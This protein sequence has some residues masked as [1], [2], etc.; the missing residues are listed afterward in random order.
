MPDESSPAMSNPAEHTVVETLQSL[1]VAFV[2]AMTFRGFVTEGF[3]IPTGSMAP[4]LYGQHKRLRGNQTGFEH[5]MG[6]DSKLGHEPPL[7]TVPDPIL[8]PNFPNT[9]SSRALARTRMGDRILV[10]K[11]LYPFSAPS[12]FDVVVFKN[13]TN[14]NGPDGNYIKRL[15]GLPD[16]SVWLV[17]GDVFAGD[18]AAPENEAAYQV[19]R[20]PEHVQRAV[21]QPI[22]HSDFYPR[23][24]QDINYRHGPWQGEGWETDETPR[25]RCETADPT[26]LE[27]DNH[28]R[29]L[30]DWAPY[31]QL[32]NQGR[33][34]QS[35][36]YVN[37]FRVAG[38]VVPDEAGLLMTLQIEARGFVYEFTIG[39]GLASARMR[40][41]AYGN[42]LVQGEGT[43]SLVSVDAEQ[44]WEVRE[45]ELETF[46][47]GRPTDVEFWHVD[48]SMAIFINGTRVVD[49]AYDW[50]PLE[51]LQAMTGRADD[52]AGE[53]AQMNPARPATLRWMMEGSSVTMQR[54]RVDRDIYYRTDR[55][56]SYAQRNPT[57]DP[58]KY[59][60]LVRSRQHAFGTH[61]KNLAILGPD[62]FFM[63]GDNSLASSD[64]RVWGNPHP[65][66]ATQID[67]APFVVNRKLLLGKAWVVYFPSP[68]SITEGGT[69]VIPDFGRLRFI[70]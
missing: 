20:K 24:A 4:T 54:V 46:P 34:I 59:D 63:A 25:F 32:L 21:W 1:I 50:T 31:N 45:V 40:S 35:P 36:V 16:E 10:L 48:Q 37:D 70:R 52:A 51:R 5:S 56:T 61:P 11:S 29:P 65:V 6:W 68:H 33:R 8:G 22:F 7:N 19:Q 53:M 13:P 49:L 2:L 60:K 55:I 43:R 39:E 58:E 64:S 38:A 42:E 30:D 23:E 18:A 27:W 66:V 28:I 69:A 9:G 26:T 17:D 47:A 12:R 67:D 14:P 44:G 57:R 15:I 3:V 41:S 62:H